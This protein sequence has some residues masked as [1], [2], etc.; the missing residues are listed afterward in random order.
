MTKNIR[1]E[2][3]EDATLFCSSGYKVEY[4]KRE[5]NRLMKY[6]EGFGWIITHTKPKGL[7]SLYPTPQQERLMV[8]AALIIFWV[9]VA[10]VVFS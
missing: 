3:P 9:F 5:G 2:A 8:F 10:W 7:H 6:I 1:R 4:Y